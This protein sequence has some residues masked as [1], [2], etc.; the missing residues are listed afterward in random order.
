MMERKTI[1][2]WFWAWDFDKEEEWLEN[3]ARN[4]WVLDGV[5][6]CTYHFIKSE[7][8]EYSV[9]LQYLPI[10]E[11]NTDYTNL[12][13]ESGAER[14]GRMVQWVYYRKKTADG[15]FQLFSDLDSRITHLDKIAKLMLIVAGA[16]LLIG[17]VN[18]YNPSISLGWINLL[19]ASL[20]TY[21][22]GRIHGKKETLEKERLF[23]E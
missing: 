2:K 22:I 17:V 23:R 20:V 19:V 4:G 3:M 21:G 14:V 15:P 10:A 8:G 11:E 7:P 16:N 1:R 9:R 13:E 6:F 12:L 5:G 18:S